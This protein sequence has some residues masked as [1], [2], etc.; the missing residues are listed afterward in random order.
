MAYLQPFGPE[1]FRIPLSEA[2]AENIGGRAALGRA[3][4]AMEGVEDAIVS[5]SAALVVCAHAPSP[6]SRRELEAAVGRALELCEHASNEV[7]RIRE[8]EVVY[9]G[10]D[11]LEVS[12]SVG[13]ATEELVA[14]HSSTP[15]RVSFLGFLPGFAYLRGLGEPLARVPRR[16][17][18]RAVVPAFSVAIAAGMSA[19]YPAASPGGWQLL[20]R[21]VGF[22]PWA[23]PL[24]VGG[25]IRFR[26]V[27]PRGGTAT[28]TARTPPQGASLEVSAVAGPALVVDGRARNRL[29]LGAPGGGPLVPSLAHH[30]L[31]AVGGD[32]EHAVVERYGSITLR[33][34]GDRPRR[35]ADESGR[36]VTLAP[37]ERHTF[38]PPSGRRVGYV[39]IEGGL[40]VPVVLGGRGTILAIR[41]GGHEGR[42]LQRGDLLALGSRTSDAQTVGLGAP[43]GRPSFHRGALAALAGPDLLASRQSPLRVRIAHTSDR[44]GTRLLP[45]EPH[46]LA[47]REART[48]PMWRGAIQAPPSGELIVLGPDHPVTGGYPVVGILG[49]D[50]CEAL[51]DRPLGTEVALQIEP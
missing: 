35:I 34:R 30:A 47:T 32:R 37:G 41:R 8:I 26:S 45:L 43:T 25:E 44:A 12:R 19:V 5:E 33:L 3:L 39:A 10:L 38:A 20:G 13:L 7:P 51:F 48:A 18:P 23:Q 1:A 17:S 24:A 14:L 6:R 27:A 21:A 11:L 9:D 28:A 42:V 49:A 36:S 15:Q 46:G 31:G 16:V 40:D 2:W 4:L 50:A 22:D 29:R